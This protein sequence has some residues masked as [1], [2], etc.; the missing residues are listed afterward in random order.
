MVAQKAKMCLGSPTHQ[1]CY[2]MCYV[3]GYSQNLT[4]VTRTGLRTRSASTYPQ[5]KTRID[6]RIRHL[7]KDKHCCCRDSH[8]HSETKHYDEKLNNTGSNTVLFIHIKTDQWTSSST[9][10][11]AYT[12][13]QMKLSKVNLTDVHCTC[14]E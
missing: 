1:Y 11:S 5:G 4:R 14:R 3:L 10:F 6:M 12:A 13:S 9:K 2:L 8:T 7:H